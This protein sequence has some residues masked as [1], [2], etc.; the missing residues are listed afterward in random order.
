[1]DIFSAIPPVSLAPQSQD[2]PTIA[3][4]AN[5]RII[6]ETASLLLISVTTAIIS[7]AM[8]VHRSARLNQ[9]GVV[10]IIAVFCV[11]NRQHQ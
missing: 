6:V 5:A 2:T 7:T 11:S 8:D 9:D 10:R 3:Q 4:L 1:M